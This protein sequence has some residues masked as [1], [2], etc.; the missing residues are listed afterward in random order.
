M[1]IS[2]VQL[3]LTAVWAGSMT[4]IGVPHLLPPGWSHVIR[5][6][7]GMGVAMLVAGLIAWPYFRE[8]N[9]YAAR[10]SFARYAAVMAVEAV[11]IFIIWVFVLA[12]LSPFD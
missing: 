7:A 4:L 2:G 1:H 9:P 8:R 10:W 6:A 12:R 3:W 5:E 11:C